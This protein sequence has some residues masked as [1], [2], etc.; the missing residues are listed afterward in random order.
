MMS[1]QPLIPLA[2]PP[3]VKQN[4]AALAMEY[5]R[6]ILVL[7]RGLKLGWNKRDQYLAAFNQTPIKAIK[8]T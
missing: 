7:K 2:P 8:K 4:P 5:S 1:K 3:I 6:A